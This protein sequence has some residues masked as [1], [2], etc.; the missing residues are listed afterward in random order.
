MAKYCVVL[1][2]G[3]TYFMNHSGEEELQKKE[4]GEEM[5]FITTLFWTSVI[6]STVG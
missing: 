6:A 2:V 3:V 5:D 4:A 1:L